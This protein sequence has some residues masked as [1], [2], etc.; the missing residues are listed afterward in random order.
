MSDVTCATARELIPDLIAGR[1]ATGSLL[2]VEGHLDQCSECRA[3]L[4]LV[5]SLYVSRR[6]PPTDLPDRIIAAG[7]RRVVDRRPWWGLTAAAIAALA[8]GIGITS[9]ANTRG[10]DLEVPGY[11]YEVEEGALWLSD[12]GLLAGAP[13]LDVLS[14]EALEALLD[15]LLTG[16]AGGSA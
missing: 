6:E 13:S 15:E 10:D 2:E 12:D 3:E 14:D 11:A 1:L 5:R 8:V 9:E 7:R 16:S 4:E